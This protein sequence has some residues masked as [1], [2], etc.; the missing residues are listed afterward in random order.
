MNLR[1]VKVRLSCIYSKIFHKGILWGCKSVKCL[2]LIY[3]FAYTSWIKQQFF[4]NQMNDF[5]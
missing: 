3:V 1:E 2:S 4:Y 5:T